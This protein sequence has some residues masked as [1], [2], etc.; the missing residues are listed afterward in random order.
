MREAAR[1]DVQ[2]PMV[3]DGI[4]VRTSP[5]NF[6]PIRSLRLARFDGKSFRLFGEMVSVPEDK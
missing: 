2:L 1:L 5:T 3:V 6:Y 4:R